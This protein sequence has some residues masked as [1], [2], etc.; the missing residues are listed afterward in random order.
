LGA[1]K[2]AMLMPAP[3]S[4]CALPVPQVLASRK[5]N[6]SS[7]MFADQKTPSGLK[8]NCAYQAIAVASAWTGAPSRLTLEASR[9][10]R[11]SAVAVT[12]IQYLETLVQVVLVPL[13]PS[14]W[15]AATQKRWSLGSQKVRGAKMTG[16][17]WAS[18]AQPGGPAGAGTLKK[19]SRPLGKP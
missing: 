16:W 12:A 7:N 10:A 14:I 11:G 6:P 5:R 19:V 9:A 15:R 4:A 13:A 8:P 2:Q 17:P 18:S 3:A 1:S